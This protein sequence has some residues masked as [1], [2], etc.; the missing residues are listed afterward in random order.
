VK[1]TPALIFIPAIRI[2]IFCHFEILDIKQQKSQKRLQKIATKMK[3]IL[4]PI[5]QGGGKCPPFAVAQFREIAQDAF[6]V[7]RHQGDRMFSCIAQN[8]PKSPN[9]LIKLPKIAKRSPITSQNVAQRSLK[10]SQNCQTFS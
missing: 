2:L 5:F 8:F 9:V 6:A 3:K 10:T 1:V 4:A 7:H